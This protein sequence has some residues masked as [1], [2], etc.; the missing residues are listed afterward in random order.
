MTNARGPATAGH[1]FLSAIGLVL[2]TALAAGAGA[3]QPA[4]QP[5]SPP[6]PEVTF[7]VEVNYVEEAV[8]VVDRDGTSSAG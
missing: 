1:Y 6:T 3:D 5:S 2:A 8:R 7:K 4:A